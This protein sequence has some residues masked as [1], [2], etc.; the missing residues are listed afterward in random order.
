MKL[1]LVH[2][3]AQEEYEQESLKN[4]WVNAL[5]KG[6][7][8]SDLSLPKDLSIEFPYYGKLLVNSIQE[9]ASVQTRIEAMR[10]DSNS[11]D[12]SEQIEFYETFL[13]EIAEKAEMSPAE[14]AELRI[15]LSKNRGVQNWEIVHK[16]STLLDRNPIIANLT[17]GLVTKD[18]F[19]YLYVNNIKKQINDLVAKCFDDEP[20]VVVGHSLGSVVSYLVLQ[21]NPQFQVKQF[22]TVGSP[23]GINGIRRKLTKV[24][25]PACVKN[26]WYNA[27]DDRDIVALNPLNQEFFNVRP[28][29][30]NTNHVKN[31]TSNR[32]GIDGYLDDKEVALEIYKALIS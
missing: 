16:L 23:L 9:A 2:G 3:R 28:S 4:E 17:L 7:A 20:C 26:G 22:I 11:I 30:V 8:K 13:G 14:R 32:H 18:V 1:I 27:F 12:E 25:V 31:H 6:L 10:G 19:M 29:I 21:N 24:G 15:L 5:Q